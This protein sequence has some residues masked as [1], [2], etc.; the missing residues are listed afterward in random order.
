MKEK[1]I[2]V[3]FWLRLM[4]DVLDSIF[5]GLFGL[6]LFIPFKNLFYRLGEDGVWVGFCITFLYTGILQSAIGRGQSLAKRLFRIQ[7]LRRN[8]SYL[9][10][11]QSFLRYSIIAFIFY[12]Q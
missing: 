8:G 10:L 2:V 6:L 5:L 7:V 9:T 12:N 11:P 4:T 3:G 1:N